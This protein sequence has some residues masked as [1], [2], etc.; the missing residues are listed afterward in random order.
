M[1]D[2]RLTSYALALALFT[3]ATRSAQATPTLRKQVDQRGNFLLLGNTLGQDCGDA[4]PQPAVGDVGPCGDD[5]TDSAPDVYWRSDSPASG[6]AEANVTVEGRNARSTAALKLPAGASVTYARL[7]W[8]A[9]SLSGAADSQVTLDRPGPGAFSAAVGADDSATSSRNAYQATA[10]V[11][12]IVRTNG[13]GAYRLGGVESAG[14]VD[15]DNS[16]NFAAWWLVVF[17]EDASA[18]PRNLTLFDGLDEVQSGQDQ[19]AALSGFLVPAAG[20]DARLGVVT[21]EG[22]DQSM[23]DSLMLGAASNLGAADRLSDDLNPVDNF[24]NSTRSE[25]GQPVSVA[26][27]LPQLNGRARSMG[28][29]DLDVIDV[30]SRLTAGQNAVNIQAISAGDIYY[31]GAFITA[32]S[33]FKPDFT[34]ST[35][36]VTDLDG[37]G[38]LPGDVLEYVIDV[39]NS[40]NDTAVSVVAV[41]A[42]PL[43]VSYVPGTLRIVSGPNAGAKSDAT[44]ADQAEYDSVNRRVTFRVGAGANSA[45]GGSLA[46]GARSSLAFRVEVD[47]DAAGSLANQAEISASGQQGSPSASWPT[48]GNGA[49]AG[50]PPTVTVIDACDTSAQCDAPTPACDTAPSPNVCVEC[51]TRRDCPAT[52]PVCDVAQHC[53]PC[54]V[55]LDCAGRTPLCDAAQG[56]CVGCRDE[57][58][59]ADPEPVCAADTHFCI[60]APTEEPSGSGGEAGAPSTEGPSPEAGAGGAE[61]P[62]NEAGAPSVAGASEAAAAGQAGEFAATTSLGFEGG[63]LSCSTGGD[64][65]RSGAMGLLLLGAAT[66]WLRRTRRRA[67]GGRA[68]RA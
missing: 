53:G 38:I 15:V 43:G 32:I 28:G 31:L 7:Y 60:A 2:R 59:C 11:T 26:G 27:D 10:D 22:D 68:S 44:D 54:Q 29:F 66:S 45:Q 37:G 62:S 21:Y 17:Y 14:F 39:A 5:T 4:V 20:F 1:I 34:T 36:T 13:E 23:G 55:D 61:N 40:G 65:S 8:A 35:K 46:A 48:D 16:V 25:L 52:A 47:A 33:T 64:R 67:A 18:P 42:L 30:T 58:D 51:L 24:F 19:M 9:Q 56:T 50:S 12:S 49:G 63:G 6:D 3:V 41:D 57:R